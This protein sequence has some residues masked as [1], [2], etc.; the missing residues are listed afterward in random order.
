MIYTANYSLGTAVFQE[1]EDGS[2]FLVKIM[3]IKSDSN[4]NIL[5]GIVPFTKKENS[6][7]NL[8]DIR[9]VLEEELYSIN[10]ILFGRKNV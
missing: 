3:R 7:S 4:G 1:L 9:Y 6:F 10:E 5:Y 2:L 8:K